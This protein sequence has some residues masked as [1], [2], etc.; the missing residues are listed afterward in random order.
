MAPLAEGVPVMIFATL[1]TSFMIAFY[2]H[3]K[4]KL[5]RQWRMEMQAAEE[6]RSRS[7]SNTASAGRA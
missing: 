1:T 3:V 7:G 4:G 5:V 2:L 6:E